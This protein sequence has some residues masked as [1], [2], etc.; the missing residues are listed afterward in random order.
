MLIKKSEYAENN[1]KNVENNMLAAAKTCVK[2]YV[3]MSD[4]DKNLPQCGT[5]LVDVEMSRHHT[6]FCSLLTPFV[7]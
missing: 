6:A 2:G 4:L 3:S 1:V 5:P 7:H